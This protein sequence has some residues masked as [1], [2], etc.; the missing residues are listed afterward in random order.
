MFT[1]VREG[2]LIYSEGDFVSENLPSLSQ[3]CMFINFKLL[4]KVVD[5]KM[6]AIQFLNMH[7]DLYINCRIKSQLYTVYN[8]TGLVL[9]PF[10]LASIQKVKI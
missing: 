9:Q 5:C 6:A 1:A 10:C 8:A 7:V 3:I 2:H 4:P